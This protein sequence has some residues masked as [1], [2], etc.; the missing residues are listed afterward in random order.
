MFTGSCCAGAT[1]PDP[2]PTVTVADGGVAALTVIVIVLLAVWPVESVTVKETLLVPAAV[3]VPLIVAVAAV[4]HGSLHHVFQLADVA[5]PRIIHQGVE[6]PGIDLV[7]ANLMFLGELP[8]ELLR[9]RNDI[10]FAMPQRRDRELQH[11]EAIVQVLAKAVL[12]RGGLAV[13]PGGPFGAPGHIRLSFAC[14]MQTLEK[15]LERMQRV[16]STG[17]AQVAKT[18]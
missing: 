8:D 3:A 7:D 4:N 2:E 18:A 11:V 14:S 15:A 12:E 6:H 9:Q 16:L 13:V 17:T 5:R 1:E 10:D